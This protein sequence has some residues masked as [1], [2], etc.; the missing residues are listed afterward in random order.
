MV[1][2][3]QS[4]EV[5][6]VHDRELS[7]RIVVRGMLTAFR[8]SFIISIGGTVIPVFLAALSAFGLSKLNFKGRGFSTP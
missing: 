5:H 2:A 6:A 8:N 3:L 7:K 1:D 4:I